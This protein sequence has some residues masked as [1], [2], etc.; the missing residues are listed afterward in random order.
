MK[1]PQKNQQEKNR[2]KRENSAQEIQREENRHK[3]IRV[4][5]TQKEI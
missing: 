4:K 2:L 5:K 3:K 1:T